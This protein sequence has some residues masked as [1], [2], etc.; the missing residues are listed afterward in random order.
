MLEIALTGAALPVLMSVS[1][2]AEYDFGACWV[3]ERLHATCTLRN[4]CGVLPLTFS[5]R[6]IAHFTAQPAS[7]RIRPGE[8]QRVEVTFAPNQIGE[9]ASSLMLSLPLKATSV[10]FFGVFF[11]RNSDRAAENRVSLQTHMDL[12]F[13][14]GV[15]VIIPKPKLG[16]PAHANPAHLVF[17]PTCPRPLSHT[18]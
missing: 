14:V 6:R 11:I 17:K 5:F 7:G 2:G 12:V 3:G 13:V 8:S 10:D 16:T 15:V 9:F 18:T 4:D 1:P